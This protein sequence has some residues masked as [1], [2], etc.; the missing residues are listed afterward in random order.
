MIYCVFL[1]DCL[2]RPSWIFCWPSPPLFHCFLFF[3]F[4]DRSFPDFC[5]IHWTHNYGASVLGGRRGRL[6]SGLFLDQLPFF[7]LNER[8]LALCG[9]KFNSTL[10]W[11]CTASVYVVFFLRKL[12]TG[13]HRLYS[14]LRTYRACPCAKWYRTRKL[15]KALLLFFEI[16][17]S[18]TSEGSDKVKRKFKREN[19]FGQNAVCKERLTRHEAIDKDA[20]GA[21]RQEATSDFL[22]LKHPRITVCGRASSHSKSWII[23]YDFCVCII[24]RGCNLQSRREGRDKINKRVCGCA[25][26]IR[27]RDKQI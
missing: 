23:I 16:E 10:Q 15:V 27:T 26:S 9:P 19:K 4:F 20:T 6:K 2:H 21:H 18:E 24:R 1:Q 17:R 22:H 14:V 3:F 7:L 5:I 25:G 12:S 8:R 11:G 13:Q